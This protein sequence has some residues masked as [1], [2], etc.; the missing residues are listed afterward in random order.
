MSITNIYIFYENFIVNFA[1]VFLISKNDYYRISKTKLMLCTIFLSL[2][3]IFKTSNL[4][5]GLAIQLLSIIIIIHFLFK[6]KKISKYAK[7]VFIFLFIYI[8]YIGTIIIC[9]L[10]FNINLSSILI[11]TCIYVFTSFSIYL[12]NVYG[13]KFWKS[14]LRESQLKYIVK[15]NNK[16]FDFFLDTGN[17]LKDPIG[18]YD[19]LIIDENDYARK[20]KCCLIEPLEV[21]SINCNT[22]AGREELKGYLLKDIEIY[23][24]GFKKVVLKKCIVLFTDTNIEGGKYS[25]IIGYD[26][27]VNKLGGV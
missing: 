16:C 19:V 27:F 25:G 12:I 18:L 17:M 14:K 10:L 21:I 24:E 6:P 23:K 8:E 26:T 3:S 7:Y 2:I 4:L 20:I 13:W 11:R 1:V 15:I 5:N 22:I 9:T